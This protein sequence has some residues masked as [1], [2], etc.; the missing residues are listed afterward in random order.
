MLNCQI[1]AASLDAYESSHA[2]S[3][4]SLAIVQQPSHTSQAQG[5][6]SNRGSAATQSSGKKQ[7]TANVA[8]C[9]AA[10][11]EDAT[12]GAIHALSENIHNTQGS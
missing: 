4:A 9:S 12:K 8:E 5:Q 7:S 10:H 1:H 3:H 6:I 2:C 11:C